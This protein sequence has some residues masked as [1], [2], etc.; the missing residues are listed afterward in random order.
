MS[1][2]V[3]WPLFSFYMACCCFVG[4]P[5]SVIEKLHLSFF[6]TDAFFAFSF[7]I[8]D[9]LLLE[10]D[11]L[12]QSLLLCSACNFMGLS[13]TRGVSTLLT[14]GPMLSALFFVAVFVL[15]MCLIGSLLTY[16]SL[17][18]SLCCSRRFFLCRLSI[19]VGFSRASLQG[20]LSRSF[21][22]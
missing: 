12:R 5:T 11:D 18:F 10:V 19:N 9:R 16:L 17:I 6:F 21:F 7:Y 8:L 13:Q 1:Y 4:H 20:A 3:L 22:S 14:L 15:A 2:L